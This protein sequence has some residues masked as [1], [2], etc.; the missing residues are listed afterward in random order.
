MIE[1]S[2]E[3]LER[4]E[5]RLSVQK[6]VLNLKELSN[7]LG[8]SQSHIYKLTSEGKIPFYK[9]SG[10]NIYFDRVEID[11]WILQNRKKTQNEIEGEAIDFLTTKKGGYNG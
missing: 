3:K 1:K 2:I 11:K 9:P 6:S 5:S 10:K 7:Y 4:I 8:L